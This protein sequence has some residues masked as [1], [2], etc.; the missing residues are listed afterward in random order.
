MKF[1][2]GKSLKND[3]L[4]FG[5]LCFLLIGIGFFLFF[6]IG[7]ESF[8]EIDIR[9]ILNNGIKNMSIS[10]TII[11]IIFGTMIII[12]LIGF[13][14]RLKYLISFAGE[15][16]FV[17]AK[18]VD[19]NYSRDRCGVD[20]EFDFEGNQCKKHFALMNNSQTKYVHMDSDVEL[21][22]KDENPKKALI[23]DLYFDFHDL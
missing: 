13:L 9:K 12:S 20:V 18:V 1:N 7:P 19:I 17:D 6:S 5:L 2:F 8:R 4:L 21:I 3:Y 16:Q 14:V 11:G 15:E 23:V 22:I 10:D